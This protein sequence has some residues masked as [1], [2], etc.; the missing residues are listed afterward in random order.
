[1]VD[2]GHSILTSEKNV[3]GDN[4]TSLKWVQ[5]SPL[6]NW[7]RQKLNRIR[8]LILQTTGEAYEIDRLRNLPLD[9]NFGNWILSD[10]DIDYGIF[11]A[12]RLSN[13]QARVLAF[14]VSEQL[15]SL[16]HGSRGWSKFAEAA[17]MVGINH[18]QLEVR[19]DNSIA[20][21]MYHRRG[22]RPKGYISGFYG[23]NDGWLM[24]GPLRNFASSQ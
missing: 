13:T 8:E 18:V 12:M 2:D 7:S 17:R 3:N 6:K 4:L 24:K 15:Q 14:S 1:V 5:S 11:W 23:G 21:Q 10:G 22:L 9:E 19:Q 20:I 16:G